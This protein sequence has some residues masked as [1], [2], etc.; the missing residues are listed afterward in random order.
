MPLVIDVE[1]WG[2]IPGKS[3]KQVIDEIQIFITTVE[4]KSGKRIMIYSNESSYRKYIKG[5]FDK[6]DIWICSFSKKP[7]INKWTF[8]QYS[9]K[10][11]LEGASGV[12]DINIFNGSKAEWIKFLN[13]KT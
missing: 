8:W 13:K 5:H 1:E 4:N 9:H 10:G 7:N 12:I 11:K 2:N 3:T 6:H